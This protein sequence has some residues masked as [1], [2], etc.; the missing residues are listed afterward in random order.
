MG[1]IGIHSQFPLDL[2]HPLGNGR[3]FH[4]VIILGI[5]LDVHQRAAVHRL[6][7]LHLEVVALAFKK[8]DC[9]HQNRIGPDRM[10]HPAFTRLIEAVLPPLPA[11]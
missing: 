7:A 11:A 4:P 5:G 1:L 6:Q 9:G 3:V 8:P 2:R 10:Y